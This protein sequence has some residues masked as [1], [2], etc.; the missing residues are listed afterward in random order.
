[1]QV[2]ILGDSNL[3]ADSTDISS[4]AHCYLNLGLHEFHDYIIQIPDGANIDHLEV[5]VENGTVAFDITRGLKNVK[6]VTISSYTDGIIYKGGANIG[7][8]KIYTN[9]SYTA[10][11]ASAAGAIGSVETK[12]LISE[13]YRI[14]SSKLAGVCFGHGTGDNV[15][16]EATISEA[17]GSI[18]SVLPSAKWVAPIIMW[19][20]TSKDISNCRILPGIEKGEQASLWTSTGITPHLISKE[21][22]GSDV[23]NFGRSYSDEEVVRAFEMAQASAK[24]TCFM[25][26][27]IVDDAAKSW[28]GFITGK[29]S[30]VE[31]FYEAQY[32]PF[33]MHYAELLRGKVN[34]FVIGTELRD[35]NA[36]HEGT[37]YPFVD[38]LIRLAGEVKAMLGDGVTVTY[39]ANWDEYHHGWNGSECTRQLDKLWAF[40]AI[41]VVGIHAYFPLTDKKSGKVT[42]EEVRAVWTS[43]EAYDYYVNYGDSRR[44][45]QH[46]DPWW[47]F[48]N[49]Q[50]WWENEHFVG[51]S[52][53]EWE[54]RSKKLW[55]TELG[56]A[57]IDKTTNE[58][59]IF[60]AHPRNSSGHIAIDQMLAGYAGSLEYLTSLPFVGNVFS[61]VWDIRGKDWYKDPKWKDRSA[62]YT[63][64]FLDGKIG[65]IILGDPSEVSGGGV[66]S[67]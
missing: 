48:K 43:G 47:A 9:Y 57:S 17:L 19:A 6:L 33:I 46:L 16:T 39:S 52:K 37:Y 10:P 50:Y 5:V 28:R 58:P 51:S 63:G 49:I 15:L 60:G 11:E 2:I 45:P 40:P 55:F 38:C 54:P 32:R 27:V 24:Q 21:A 7:D 8:L 14:I 36:I 3:C 29:V 31:R 25:P 41:D 30:D 1:M 59:H 62:W 26:S 56:F 44:V 67:V 61:Y 65:G 22:S 4:G 42:R 18:G 13:D 34:A 64:H 35:L 66:G 53:T 23:P 20:A 12:P